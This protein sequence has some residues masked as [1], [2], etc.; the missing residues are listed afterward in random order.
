MEMRHLFKNYLVLIPPKEPEPRSPPLKKMKLF[1]YM[2]KSVL[3]PKKK[4]SCTEIYLREE[5]Q[6]VDPVM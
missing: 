1:S 6:E 5:E 3:V 4:K 2:K